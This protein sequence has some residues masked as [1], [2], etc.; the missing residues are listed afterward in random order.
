MIK[1]VSF[2]LSGWSFYFRWP[3]S[4]RHRFFSSGILLGPALQAM[5]FWLFSLLFTWIWQ[6]FKI[7]S[8]LALIALSVITGFFHEDGFADAFDSLGVPLMGDLEVARTKILAA[9]RDSR[10]G[11]FG[12]SALCAL[13]MAR[14]IGVFFYNI[15]SVGF[16]AVILLS[17]VCGLTAGA[18]FINRMGQRVSPRASHQLLDIEWYW[19]FLSFVFAASLVWVVLDYERISL[20]S[21]SLFC[22]LVPFAS[23]IGVWTWSRRSGEVNGDI[24]GAS[25]CLGEI[26]AI[27]AMGRLIAVPL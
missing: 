21:A 19:T 20:F 14:G 3:T 6:D 18:L 4:P 7:G 25:I 22:L 17:R 12:V 2:I 8:L 27:F 15:S 11:T 5:V 23:I 26:V 13:W 9:M 16:V 10:L 1:T 24:V